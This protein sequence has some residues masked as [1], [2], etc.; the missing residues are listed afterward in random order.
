MHGCRRGQSPGERPGPR[1]RAGPF[2][3]VREWR[4]QVSVMDRTSPV[5]I[6]PAG[7]GVGQDASR[8]GQGA[9]P[10][11]RVRVDGRFFARGAARVRVHGVTY[12]PFAP[13]EDGDPFP[14]PSTVADDFALM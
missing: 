4:D 10:A 3:R 7:D 6:A 14:A 12:G 8:N 13:N 9:A 11:G 2:A 5:V 1:Q